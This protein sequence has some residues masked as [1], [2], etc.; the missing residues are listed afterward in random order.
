MRNNNIY[1]IILILTVGYLIFKLVLLPEVFLPS[2]CNPIN[3][4]I[5]TNLVTMVLFTLYNYYYLKI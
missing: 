2:Q 1:S 5:V 3:T 4:K